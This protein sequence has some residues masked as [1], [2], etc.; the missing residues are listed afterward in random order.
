MKHQYFGDENDYRKYGLIR[1][2]S[3]EGKLSVGVWWMLT[4]DDGGV[5]GKFT[6][7]LNNSATRLHDVP[8]HDHL[9]VALDSGSRHLSHI[10]RGGILPNT[11]FFS[12]VVP[13]ALKP[14]LAHADRMRAVLGACDLLFV[15]PDNGIEVKSTPAGRKDS[16]KYVRWSEIAD[17]HRAG[18]S[19]LVYQHF[20]RQ[21]RSR[22]TPATA[23]ELAKQTGASH[24][25]TFS[26]SRV[27]F[28]LAGQEKHGEVLRDGIRTIREQWA[29]QIT[30][31][32]HEMS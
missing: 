26:T 8:L 2:L 5:D 4:E 28:L 24:V 1:A 32:S 10:E 16:S 29:S 25:D 18:Q 27:L 22:F 3:G 19:V 14:R 17:A 12:E 7:Y 15:D 11:R 23:S 6:K 30:H 13:D 21:A 31:Q 9:R 20:P